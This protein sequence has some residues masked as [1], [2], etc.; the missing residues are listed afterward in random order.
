MVEIVIQCAMRKYRSLPRIFVQS[1]IVSYNSV[2]L[3]VGQVHYLIDVMRRKKGDFVRIFNADSGEW[4]AE[5]KALQKR[6]AELLP[7][8]KIRD[9]EQEAGPILL[10]APLKRPAI[11]F[12]I[13][14]ATE[15]GVSELRPVITQNTYVKKLNQERAK[16]HIIEASEQCERISIPFLCDIVALRKALDCWDQKIPLWVADETLEEGGELSRFE[17][18]PTQI[19]ILI[20]PEGGFTDQERLLFQQ[21]SFIKKISLGP[22]ILRAETAAIVGLTSLQ[23]FKSVMKKDSL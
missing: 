8:E 1:K 2:Q 17:K 5:I 9:P 20:G 21:Y 7:V 23:V 12:L 18:T 4:C 11:D 16:N 22:R 6:S 10:F 15:L 13:E 19:A 14:K 3:E